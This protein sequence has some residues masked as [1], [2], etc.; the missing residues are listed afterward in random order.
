MDSWYNRLGRVVYS[1]MIPVLNDKCQD[2]NKA[3]GKRKI[4]ASLR[5]YVGVFLRPHYTRGEQ[6][7]CVSTPFPIKDLSL[8][9]WVSEIDSIISDLGLQPALFDATLNL[10]PYRPPR[11]FA[12][13]DASG[14][15]ESDSYQLSW[16][17]DG[18]PLDVDEN[19]FE[20]EELQRR[21]LSEKIYETVGPPQRVFPI[22]T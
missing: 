16:Q 1:V 15:E 19:A 2:H 3:S 4:R 5:E 17:K 20:F 18:V 12:S 9:E 7:Q 14:D 8:A 13:L 10:D 11:R 21:E 6:E 22:L